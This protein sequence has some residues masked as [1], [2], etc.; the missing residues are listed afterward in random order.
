MKKIIA[1]LLVIVALISLVS[2]SGLTDDPVATAKKLAEEYGDECEITIMMGKEDIEDFADEYDTDGEGVYAILL[3]E[4]DYYGVIIYCE[5]TTSAKDIE[6]DLNKYI[7]NM[8]KDPYYG[9]YYK[10]AVVE[11]NGKVVYCGHEDILEDIKA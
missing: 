11:R 2:C 4:C 6:K 10:D 7:K 5:D 3:C 1:L 9:S 8:K